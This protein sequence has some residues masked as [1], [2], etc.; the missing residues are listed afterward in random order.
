MA[1]PHR[2]SARLNQVPGLLLLLAVGVPFTSASAR[3]AV[4]AGRPVSTRPVRKKLQASR[5]SKAGQSRARRYSFHP[6]TP[7]SPAAMTAVTASCR[8]LLRPS[9]TDSP[10]SDPRI[11]MGGRARDPRLNSV[12]TR[13]DHGRVLILTG[14][15][16]LPG[17][18]PT[19]QGSPNRLGR[20]LSN[21]FPPN[22]GRE[23][24]PGLRD[25]LSPLPTIERRIPT[26]EI[27]LP[28]RLV[29][30]V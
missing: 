22:L 4:A 24:P 12:L 19:A 13:P 6:Q 26:V 11:N 15:N 10:G 2:G 14:T 5:G 29:L 9:E 7:T 3:D 1:P 27:K 18:F 20:G 17:A 28:P 21:Q 16:I 30:I 25:R 23:V 8:T